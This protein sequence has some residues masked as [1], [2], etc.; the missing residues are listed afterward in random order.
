M[1]KIYGASDDLLEFTGEIYGEIGYYDSSKE[2]PIRVRVS[3]GTEFS[4]Y[5]NEQGLWKID[6]HVKGTH[7][8]VL[9]VATDPDSEN[10][11]D[12]LTLLEGKLTAKY[13]VGKGS[14]WEKV[15]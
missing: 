14:K 10:Y 8:D 13:K 11:S 4:A 9:E 2:D 12:T 5:Y 1:T 15:R 3:D 7:F 6:V